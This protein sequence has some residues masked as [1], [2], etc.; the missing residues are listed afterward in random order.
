MASLPVDIPIPDGETWTDETG[1]TWAA[2]GSLILSDDNI[3]SVRQE[4]FD[5]LRGL[6]PQWNWYDYPPETVKVPAF[7]LNPADPYIIPYSQGGPFNALWGF[8]LVMV[9]GRGKPEDAL[10]RLEFFY[11][12]ITQALNEAPS[13]SWLEFGEV[14]TTEIGGVEHLT[15]TLTVAV[16]AE[17]LRGGI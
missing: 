12:E 16:V 6:F 3:Q 10:R 8:E 17:S 13:T 4:L 1:R 7:V 2:H 9:V 11:T 15:G 14:G 5:L